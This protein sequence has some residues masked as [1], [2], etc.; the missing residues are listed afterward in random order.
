[1]QNKILSQRIY[2]AVDNNNKRTIAKGSIRNTDLK[3]ST[4]ATFFD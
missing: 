3:I 1:M 2:Y 4:F